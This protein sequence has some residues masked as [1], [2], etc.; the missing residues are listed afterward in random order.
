MKT[1]FFEDTIKNSEA[2]ASVN[3]TKNGQGLSFQNY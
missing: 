3:D 1:C 2:I